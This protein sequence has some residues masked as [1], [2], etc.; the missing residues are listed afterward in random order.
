MPQLLD[1]QRER[2]GRHAWADALEQARLRH[3][4]ITKQE[5]ARRCGISRAQLDKYAS[6]AV[7]PP[8]KHLSAFAEALGFEFWEQLALLGWLTEEDAAQARRLRVETA[9]L[10]I[11]RD[12]QSLLQMDQ[13][14]HD[15]TPAARLASV[16]IEDGWTVRHQ[17][18]WRGDR[19]PVAFADAI[20][21]TPPAHLSRI[22]TDSPG[23][24]PVPPKESQPE[25][26]RAAQQGL[27]RGEEQL[28]AVVVELLGADRWNQHEAYWSERP[29]FAASRAAI[30]PPAPHPGLVVTVPRW[31]RRRYPGE[32]AA[33]LRR[34]ERESLTSMA[35]LGLP[36]SGA[37]DLAAEAADLLHWGFAGVAML[38]R[39]QSPVL[40]EQDPGHQL[41]AT[42]AR[43]LAS[44]EDHRA[45]YCTWA[46][47]EPAAL[48]GSV[49][50]LKDS[51]TA[52]VH[53]RLTDDS[54]D[55]FLAPFWGNEGA[56]SNRT[57]DHILSWRNTC[58]QAA[59]EY[60]RA[61][62]NADWLTIDVELRQE[63]KGDENESVR[64]DYYELHLYPEVQRWLK[65]TYGVTEALSKEDQKLLDILGKG[66]APGCTDGELAFRLDI[67]LAA[68]KV[69]VQNL[70]ARLGL[71]NRA[72][73]YTYAVRRLKRAGL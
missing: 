51:Q 40:P 36:Y 53:A 2:A 5:L 48:S 65:D 71:T 68:T 25:V 10:E 34:V 54:I 66:E 1:D 26:D 44:G 50:L 67:S 45:Q 23:D 7:T 73:L 49:H 14:V 46:Y 32:Q 8:G 21:L 6:G 60:R 28:R 15:V 17:T 59:A 43:M 3:G 69:R 52:V 70:L 37:T 72:S 39:R 31:L 64:Q 62:G 41:Q 24:Q 42:V 38:A 47:N 11:Y 19:V 33:T 22:L 55:D 9:R 29:R 30:Q 27:T 56:G 63:H 12:L 4:H 16:L 35:F 20:E 57:K 58:D 13:E 18:A 61:H